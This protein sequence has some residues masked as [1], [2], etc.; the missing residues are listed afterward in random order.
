MK[1]NHTLLLLINIVLLQNLAAQTVFVHQTTQDNVSLHVTVLDHPELNENPNK[2]LFVSQVFG[3]YN[4]NEI[5]VWYNGTNW[6]IYNQNRQALP[7]NTSFHVLA[8]D[9]APEG[10]AFVHTTNSTNIVNHMTR[11]SHPKIDADPN[12][13]IFITQQFGAHNTS[14]VGLWYDG[15]GWLIYNEMTGQAMPA[16]TKFNILIVSEGAADFGAGISG[17]SFQHTVN[18][19]NKAGFSGLHTSFIEHPSTNNSDEKFLFFNPNWQGKYNTN[20]MGLWFDNQRWVIFNQNLQEVPDGFRCN[21]LSVQKSFSTFF[22]VNN[23]TVKSFDQQNTS[24]YDLNDRPE[25]TTRYINQRKLHFI[26]LEKKR[27][28]AIDFQIK[29]EKGNVV[30]SAS[31]EAAYGFNFCAIDVAGAIANQRYTLELMSSD[32]KPQYLHYQLQP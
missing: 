6:T 20:A 8:L 1:K 16:N 23:R 28:Q 4:P 13:M 30:H 19:S 29:D 2:I 9:P 15:L 26:Y 18:A 25:T 5:G 10:S 32:N 22:D 14:P 7:Q 3:T 21:M 17:F 27:D 31:F 24:F 12:A 11:I